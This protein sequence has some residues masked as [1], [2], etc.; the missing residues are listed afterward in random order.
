MDSKQI[1]VLKNKFDSLAHYDELYEVEYWSARELMPVFGYER[2]ENFSK[3]IDK[4]ILSIQNAQKD[5]N[6]Y[7]REVTKM[8]TIGKNSARS[9]KV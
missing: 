1:A 4:T 9:V 3:V 6:Y 5:A 2:W 8:L 7:L